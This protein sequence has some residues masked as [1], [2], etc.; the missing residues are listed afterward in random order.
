MG[1]SAAP[2]PFGCVSPHQ[3]TSRALITDRVELC[4]SSAGR[5]PLTSVSSAH[6]ES[7]LIG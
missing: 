3:L 6:C 4:P 2:G 5:D 1:F 7:D